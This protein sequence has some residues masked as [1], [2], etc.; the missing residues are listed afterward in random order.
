MVSKKDP[1]MVAEAWKIAAELQQ[2]SLL[3]KMVKPIKGL[4]T[5][6]KGGIQTRKEN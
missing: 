6:T 5:K 1:E 3:G 4:K 2:Q